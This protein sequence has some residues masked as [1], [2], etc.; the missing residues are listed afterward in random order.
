[1]KINDAGL[2]LIKSF[3]TCRLKTYLDAVGIPTIG[4]GHTGDIAQIGREIDQATADAILCEDLETAEQGVE[5]RLKVKISENQFSAL[6]CLTYNIG[7]S[8][9]GSS[10]LLKLL[11]KGDFQGAA[12][13][14][15]RWNKSQG[16]A[17]A[18]LTRRRKAERAL[19]ES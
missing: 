8:N 1:M 12:G 16:K 7:V 4:W 15:E 9:F 10:T 5:K 19:F 6:V 17:L 11:N 18:G 13:E 2:D 3:E 14:F